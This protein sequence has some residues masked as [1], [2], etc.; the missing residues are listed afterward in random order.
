MATLQVLK[1]RAIV[2]NVGNVGR[3]RC[4]RVGAR[5]QNLAPW[6][7]RGQERRRHP[8][9]GKQAR[10]RRQARPQ[11]RPSSSFKNDT[12]ALKALLAGELDSY[13]AAPA[14]PCGGGTRRGRGK[15][16]GCNWLAAPHGVYVPCRYRFMADLKGKSVA[17]ST[18]GSFPEI[19]AKAALEKAG[20]PAG[21]VRFAR[22]GVRRRP[23]QSPDRRRCRRRHHL[24]TSTCRFPA[25]MASANLMP[26]AEVMPDFHPHLRGDGRQ[27]RSTVGATT[28]SDSLPPRS[29]R[30]ASP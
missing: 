24:P 3:P 18:P 22:H 23:L 9:H 11:A 27:G 2:R 25:R 21:Q 6:H 14:A 1:D 29:R 26:A 17:V 4:R 19:F 8:L 15:I 12:I 20:I 16:V 28:R 10:L 30:C 13:E 7:H 5:S